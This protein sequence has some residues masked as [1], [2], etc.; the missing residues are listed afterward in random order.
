MPIK[1]AAVFDDSTAASATKRVAAVVMA[2]DGSAPRRRRVDG[3]MCD[4]L[5]WQKLAGKSKVAR[6]E[7][8]ARP[9]HTQHDSRRKAKRLLAMIGRSSR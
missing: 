4:V 8:M 1:A 9:T 6:E 2:C 5:W 3:R 7:K